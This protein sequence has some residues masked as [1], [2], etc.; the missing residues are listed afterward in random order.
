MWHQDR[1]PAQQ[2]RLEMTMTKTATKTP[3]TQSEKFI[4]SLGILQHDIT[5]SLESKIYYL[6]VIVSLLECSKKDRLAI[7]ANA[8]TFLVNKEASRCIDLCTNSEQNRDSHNSF[9]NSR[10]KQNCDQQ[11]SLCITNIICLLYIGSESNKGGAL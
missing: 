3:V 7:L 11:A 2:G 9:D 5:R 6:D 1:T 10:V 8:K 4:N